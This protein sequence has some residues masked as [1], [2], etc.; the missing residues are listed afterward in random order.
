VGIAAWGVCANLALLLECAVRH[1]SW[2]VINHEDMCS[3]TEARFRSLFDQLGLEWNDRVAAHL[4][5]SDVP[6][7]GWEITRVREQESDVWKRRL[8]GPPQK[9]VL[10]IVGRFAEVTDP[11]N[12]FSRAVTM[13]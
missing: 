5:G 2:R 10:E 13:A 11:L 9:Q 6:G 1:P 3:D 8:S 12:V 7:S 4:A